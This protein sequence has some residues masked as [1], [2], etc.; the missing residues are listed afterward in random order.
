MNNREKNVR[1]TIASTFPHIKKKVYQNPSTSFLEI[2]GTSLENVVL[3]KTRLKFP[4]KKA[5]NW[6]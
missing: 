3:R 2:V 1:Q 5:T 4:M 6:V